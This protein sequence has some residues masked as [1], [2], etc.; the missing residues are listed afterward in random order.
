MAGW[1]LRSLSALSDLLAQ[2]FLFAH[3]AHWVDH[4]QLQDAPDVLIPEAEIRLG[5]Y[6]ESLLEHAIRARGL[7]YAT[8]IP[9]RQS[10]RTLGELDFVF[11]TQDGGW[12]H[13]EVAYKL[14]LYHPPSPGCA[15]ALSDFIGPN[16]IDRLDLK[17]DRMLNHQLPLVHTPEAIDAIRSH[18]PGFDPTRL[19]SRAWLKGR[20]FLPEG[21]AL[22]AGLGLNPNTLTG[23]WG[24]EPYFGAAL[25][26]LKACSLDVIDQKLSL[27]EPKDSPLLLACGAKRHF[28]LP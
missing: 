9:V 27:I 28:L 14:Y 21:V 13:W 2:P 7:P 12:E 18:L 1:E 25:S 23:T 26:R 24:R 4:D 16:K 8:R 10:G 5:H 11:Q 22:P 15:P 17:V 6:V 20:I 19:R 3:A